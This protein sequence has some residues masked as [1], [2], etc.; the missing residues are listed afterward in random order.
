MSLPPSLALPTDDELRAEQN[1]QTLLQRPDKD[2]GAQS[3]GIVSVNRV[4]ITPPA[5]PTTPPVP[6]AAPAPVPTPVPTPT[7]MSTPAP[8]PEPAAPANGG[9][10]TDVRPPVTPPPAATPPVN[11]LGQRFVR[12]PTQ[13]S[14]AEQIAAPAIAPTPTLTSTPTLVAPPPQAPNLPIATPANTPIAATPALDPNMNMLAGVDEPTAPRQRRPWLTALIVVV[15]LGLLGG[16]ALWLQSSGTIY[17]ATLQ[18][19]AGGFPKSADQAL[20]LMRQKAAT[21]YGLTGQ[22]SLIKSSQLPSVGSTDS[23]SGTTAE[24]SGTIQGGVIDGNWQVYFNWQLA[25]DYPVNNLQG[26]VMRLDQ[27][28][29][30][31]LDTLS[32]LVSN[33]NWQEITTDDWSKTAVSAPFAAVDLSG[34]LGRSSAGQYLGPNSLTVGDKTYKVAVYQYTVDQADDYQDVTYKDGRLLIWVDRTNGQ[35]VEYQLDELMTAGSLG[36]VVFESVWTVDTSA[37]VSAVALEDGAKPTS[38]SISGLAME[39]GFIKATS[40]SD[41]TTASGRDTRRRSDLLSIKEALAEYYAKTG[42]YPVSKTVD[43]TNDSK[44][45]KGAL[46]PSYLGVLPVDPQDPKSYYG[47]TSDG[48]S[49]KLTSIVEDSATAGAKQG[50]GFYYQEITN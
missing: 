40:S 2:S 24:A 43:K 21:T 33:N 38:G 3:G 7:P 47:Y 20:V 16:V 41:L 32:L 1:R 39:L 14:L 49:F 48:F 26:E 31:Y 36:D 35:V 25:S 34:L 44:V 19:I 30:V 13:L 17:N 12:R 42:T 15:V 45:L 6:V 37:T 28:R 50:S 23:A 10:A 4:P 11:P 9:T 22:A 29:Y 27:K 8:L 46:V 5:A 18:K